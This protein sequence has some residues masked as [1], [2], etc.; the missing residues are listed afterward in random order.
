MIEKS[1][2]DHWLELTDEQ[3]RQ[4]LFSMAYWWTHGP[5]DEDAVLWFAWP[6]H[7]FD[8]FARKVL[9]LYD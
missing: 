5:L 4:A 3:Y 8:A 7:P 2:F 6:N 9:R 1:H